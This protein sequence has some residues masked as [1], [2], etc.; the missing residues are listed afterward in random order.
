MHRSDPWPLAG[1]PEAMKMSCRQGYFLTSSYPECCIGALLTGQDRR[2]GP[3]CWTSA[4][5][6]CCDAWICG[7]EWIS[8]G[9]R[10]RR[11]EAAYTSS[12]REDKNAV[13]DQQQ[14]RRGLM[15]QLRRPQR[16]WFT[17]ISLSQRLAD[18]NFDAVA[19]ERLPSRLS[20]AQP[21]LC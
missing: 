4:I 18:Q 5:Y 13:D 14:A 7:E 9:P 12:C 6:T 8:R 19:V 1:N 20:K 17:P 3:R 2:S 10:S 15:A 16:P 21:R 11:F